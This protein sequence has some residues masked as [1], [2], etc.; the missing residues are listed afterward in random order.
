MS[1]VV[2]LGDI[3]VDGAALARFSRSP[4][5]PVMRDL[6]RRADRVQLGARV[7]VRKR[8]RALE[9]SIVKRPR[10]YAPR[11]PEVAIGSSLYYA[12]WEHEGTPPHVIRPN[13]M[14][15]LRFPGRG[16]AIVFARTVKH[17]GTNGSHF[18]TRALV[19]AAD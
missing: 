12:L 7:I 19:L 4:D 1:I 3:R 17:P 10:P 15:V 13:R 2:K 5:G 14:K 18:L 16:G 9:K 8:T 11:G 6:M